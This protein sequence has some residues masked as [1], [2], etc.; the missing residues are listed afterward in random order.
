MLGETTVPERIQRQ[1]C[2]FGQIYLIFP[3]SQYAKERV[4]FDHIHQLYH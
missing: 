1:T 2:Y 4:L 3:L